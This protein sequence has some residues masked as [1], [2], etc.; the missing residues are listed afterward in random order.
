LKK[1]RQKYWLLLT[2]A[3]LIV[4]IDQ[5]TKAVV[6]TAIP[7]GSRWMPLEWLA[8]YFRFVHWEN[9]GAAFGMFQE[10]GI[11]FGVLAVL[12]SIFIMF[13]YPQIPKEEK[14]MRVAMAMQLGGALGNLIDRVARGPVTDFISVGNFPVFNIAD[15]SITIGVGLLV[16]ALWI[17]ERREKN[18]LSAFEESTADSIEPADNHL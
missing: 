10:G 3:G 13:Y 18:R 14:L 12:I 5:V 2:I 6:R 16:L 4:L 1:F 8:P 9:T 17:S 15:S 11:V 7:F